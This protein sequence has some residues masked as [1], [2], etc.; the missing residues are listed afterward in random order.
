MEVVLGP[1]VFGADLLQKSSA[2][3]KII[4]ADGKR[5]SRRDFAIVIRDNLRRLRK[6]EKT[7]A[8]IIELPGTN[9]TRAGLDVSMLCPTSQL[10]QKE[11]SVNKDLIDYLPCIQTH[12]KKKLSQLRDFFSG[13]Q[14]SCHVRMRS[15]RSFPQCFEKLKW[16]RESWKKYPCYAEA[17]V[18]GSECSFL[19][20]LSEL[21]LNILGA[22]ALFNR[23][24]GLTTS[25]K[26]MRDR[27]T[28]LWPAWTDA[29][30]QYPLLLA[31]RGLSPNISLT[32][33]PKLKILVYMGFL[34]LP[35]F[36]SGLS[37]G[38][39][40]GE[41][42]QWTDLISA[43]FILGHELTI[44]MTPSDLNRQP[45]CSFH[46]LDSFG[47]HAKFNTPAYEPSPGSSSYFAKMPPS[48]WSGLSLNLKQFYTMFP[49][50]PDNSFMGF[51]VEQGSKTMGNLTELSGKPIALLYAK[52]YYMLQH[53]SYSFFYCYRVL[54]HSPQ[55]TEVMKL[56]TILTEYFEV[57]ATVAD[58]RSALPRTIIN[59]GLLAGTAYM[60]VLR[61]SK[62]MFTRKPFAWL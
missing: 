18:D 1:S 11:L 4:T 36:D 44:A 23:Q 33:S 24:S 60:N 42:V 30:H 7:L 31:R 19:K 40:Q 59:H 2:F 49:H 26:F 58:A 32:G 16:M 15:L 17:G 62:V 29:V 39:P 6:L 22:Y 57:H 28:R 51:V 14:E 5:G 10:P 21:N 35:G 43:L 37:T 20:Y 8:T 3:I 41:Y 34:H 9:H 12:T 46:I 47:T 50:T 27:M 52:K 45:I 56:I 48:P 38:G 55:P 53:V 25:V 54:S 61:S 13:A